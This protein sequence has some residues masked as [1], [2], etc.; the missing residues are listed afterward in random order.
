MPIAYNWA[1]FGTA[2]VM[3][4]FGKKFGMN[5]RMRG[6]FLLGILVLLFVP[7]INELPI[8]KDIRIW[9]CLGATFVG[10]FSTGVLTSSG[11]G[12]LAVL[13]PQFTTA[14]M[15][16][17]GVAGIVVGALQ[18]VLQFL[19]FPKMT[20]YQV[21]LSGIIFFGTAAGVMV[22]CAI[23]NEI[24]LKSRYYLYYQAKAEHKDNSINE[25]NSSS[26]DVSLIPQGPV[27]IMSVLKKIWPD[28]ISVF[29]VFQV[30]LMIFP[31]FTVRIPNY[32]PGLGPKEL[33]LT[34]KLP[35]VLISLLQVCDVV[36][37]TLPQWVVIIPKRILLIPTV[38]RAL[39]IPLWMLMCYTSFF[40]SNYYTYAAMIVMSLT[41]GYF[42]TLG[43]MYGPT[44]VSKAEGNV[45]G[46]IMV[47]FLQLG[48]FGGVHC[49]MI[50]LLIVGGP[51]AVING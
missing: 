51:S 3:I 25:L 43:M 48:I 2:F 1:N 40:A 17:Q 4:W 45:A 16:G 8:S 46:M 27:T 42:S 44:R 7:G 22:A 18:L 9:L 29:L 21:W 11:F 33:S 15:A 39:F 6:S 19:V 37:R 49:A 50:L 28:A 32:D 5:L 10:G 34:S 20:T 30:T 23:C 47:A 13:P 31:G 26:E 14:L 36:G 12:A 38:L 35:T 41:N 24:L